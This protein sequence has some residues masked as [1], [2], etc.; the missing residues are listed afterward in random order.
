MKPSAQAGIAAQECA[1]TALRHLLVAPALKPRMSALKGLFS[2]SLTNI[3]KC[4][5]SGISCDSMI[6]TCGYSRGISASASSAAMPKAVGLILAL[7]AQECAATVSLL[8]EAPS[9]AWCCASHA[10]C[11]APSPLL[12]EALSV[13]RYCASPLL[14]RISRPSHSRLRSASVTVIM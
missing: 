1:A 4:I 7:A 9:V 10:W 6:S 5:C 13:A 12:R 8:R 2:G 3:T 11:E 14:A